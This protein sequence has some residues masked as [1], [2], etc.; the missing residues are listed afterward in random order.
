MDSLR[1]FVDMVS[2]IISG[3]VNYEHTGFILIFIILL[4]GAFFWYCHVFG[5]P[6]DHESNCQTYRG[7]VTWLNFL[8]LLLACYVI[9]KQKLYPELKQMKPLTSV[10]KLLAGF[11]P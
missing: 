2:G 8:G 1:S 10:D 9:G 4:L 11:N 5:D 7:W 6:N 3:T